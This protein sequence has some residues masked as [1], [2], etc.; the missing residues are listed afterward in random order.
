MGA[1]GS[2]TWERGRE[3][4]GRDGLDFNGAHQILPFPAAAIS[5]LQ[6][7][8]SKITSKDLRRPTADWQGTYIR[9]T[10]Y[11]LLKLPNFPPLDTVF[12]FGHS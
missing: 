10:S 3:A 7:C 11:F 5:N 9:H 2:C 4:L 6:T 12:D 1:N 8:A